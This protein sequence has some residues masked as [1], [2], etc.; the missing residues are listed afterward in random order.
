LANK[1]ADKES[2]VVPEPPKAEAT[3]VIVSN[4]NT[5]VTIDNEINSEYI[6]SRKRGWTSLP[7]PAFSQPLC[8]ATNRSK[9]DTNLF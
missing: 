8:K 5:V 9:G 3:N 1:K 2:S 4:P 6:L 7:Q